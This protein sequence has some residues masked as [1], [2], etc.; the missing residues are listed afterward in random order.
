MNF[1]MFG[2][3]GIELHEKD[4]PEETFKLLNDDIYKNKKEYLYCS[5]DIFYDEIEKLCQSVGLSCFTDEFYF[6]YI[7]ISPDQMKD[8]QTLGEFKEKIKNK[9]KEIG[10]ENI[11]IEYYIDLGQT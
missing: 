8:D 1:S 6:T 5:R 7:G 4:I 2:I 3:W 9:L 10:I 11:D